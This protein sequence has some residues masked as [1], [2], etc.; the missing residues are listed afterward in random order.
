MYSLWDNTEEHLRIFSN[1]AENQELAES[2]YPS[3]GAW[4]WKVRGSLMSVS[5]IILIQTKSCESECALPFCRYS[6]HIRT[7]SLAAPKAAQTEDVISKRSIRDAL[8]F[9]ERLASGTEVERMM[10]HEKPLTR[11]SDQTWIVA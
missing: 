1:Q 10:Q 3:K 11:S 2:L 9:G 6:A 5:G 4:Q 7:N 8:S